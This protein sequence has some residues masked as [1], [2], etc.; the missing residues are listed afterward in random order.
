MIAQ[1]LRRILPTIVLTSLACSSADDGNSRAEYSVAPLMNPDDP[2]WNRAA[3]DSFDVRVSTTKGDFLARLRRGWA[4]IGVDRFYHLVKSGFYDNS[5]F[6]R[7][8][9]GF[10]VQF[11][12][13]G[14]PSV[15]ALWVDRAITD[16]PVRGSNTRGTMAY[17]MTGPDTRTTQ[18]YIN[19]GDNS[20][21][22]EQGFAPLGEV[23][24][25]MDIV[26]QLYAQYDENAGGGMRGGQQGPLLEGGNVYLDR[27]FPNLDRLMSAQIV[28]KW[29]QNAPN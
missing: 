8:R 20:R 11:G 10:I 29:P 7:V 16:D 9:A 12:I 15:T 4:P 3:P 27:E 28:Q 13:P 5:R 14:D 26:D 19:Y 22:D 17:A 6:Y 25:G 18:I 2:A 23:I 21:L 24:H 1:I